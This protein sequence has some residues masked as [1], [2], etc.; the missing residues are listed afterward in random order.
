VNEPHP[1]RDSLGGDSAKQIPRK[2]THGGT[3]NDVL[4]QVH[5]HGAA[6][7]APLLHKVS[8]QQ[9]AHSDSSLLGGSGKADTSFI[10]YTVVPLLLRSGVEYS[11]AENFGS[12][13]RTMYS[14]HEVAG[15]MASPDKLMQA[16]RQERIPVSDRCLERMRTDLFWE[17]RGGA[18]LSAA[19]SPDTDRRKSFL[20]RRSINQDPDEIYRRSVHAFDAAPGSRESVRSARRSEYAPTRAGQHPAAPSDAGAQDMDTAQLMQAAQMI[21]SGQIPPML[22]GQ[23]ARR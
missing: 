15:L 21:K 8:L 10:D 20:Y 5:P 16:V 12:V 14:A 17:R 1:S 4:K 19:A 18:D 9:H 3:R 23:S 11:A 13:L 2:S 6:G 22:R 7:P